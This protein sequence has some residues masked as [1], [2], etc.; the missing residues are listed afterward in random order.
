VIVWGICNMID[1]IK[2]LYNNKVRV[3]FALNAPNCF[4]V[5][6][7]PDT[8]EWY[9]AHIR[10]TLNFNPLNVVRRFSKNHYLVDASEFA[11]GMISDMLVVDCVELTE[12]SEVTKHLSEQLTNFDVENVNIN[13]EHDEF[14]AIFSNELAHE[15]IMD[16]WVFENYSVGE[17]VFELNMVDVWRATPSTTHVSLE[18]TNG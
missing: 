5:T 16:N 18:I 6:I 8:E 1:T 3:S 11:K 9:K 7:R 17:N 15:A 14:I 13:I 2:K 10:E 12:I 4:Y